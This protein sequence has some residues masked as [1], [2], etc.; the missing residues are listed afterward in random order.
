M[1]ELLL[2]GPNSQYG[3]YQDVDFYAS[4]GGLVMEY[5]LQIYTIKPVVS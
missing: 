5:S 1:L 4:E 2:K 3:A